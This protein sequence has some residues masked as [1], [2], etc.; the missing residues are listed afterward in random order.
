MSTLSLTRL[1]NGGGS[2]HNK[3]YN[4][5]YGS[6]P[7]RKHVPKVASVDIDMNNNAPQP[8]MRKRHILN[9]RGSLYHNQFKGVRKEL[10]EKHA[11]MIIHTMTVC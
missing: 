5:K 2:S 1:C 11:N 3:N 8:T 6:L 4:L 7:T 10:I 9:K